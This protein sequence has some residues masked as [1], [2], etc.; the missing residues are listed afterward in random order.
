[1][2]LAVVQHQPYVSNRGTPAVPSITFGAGPTN[3]N[4]MIAVLYAFNRSSA[5]SPAVASGWTQSSLFSTTDGLGF[6]VY[7]LVAY[8]YAGASEPTAQSCTSTSYA[9]ACME[10]WEVSGVTGTFANDHVADTNGINAAPWTSGTMTIASVTTSANNELMLGLTA[11]YNGGLSASANTMS[12]SGQTNDDQPSN[13]NGPE[14]LSAFH[15]AFST[16]GTATPTYTC[17]FGGNSGGSYAL[18][19]LKA[20]ASS[21][22]T[23]T[24]SMALPGVSFSAGGARTE[25]STATLALPK[26]NFSAAA[27]RTATI[28]VTM[29][30]NGI[31]IA[32][33][34]TDV[35]AVSKLRQFQT[36]G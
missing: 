11:E 6:H 25:T 4:L 30:L 33:H 7:L 35:S 1:M 21:T 8:R 31:Q 32:A 27:L 9:E 18:V 26:A 17:T 16:S 15:E 3:G 24:A 19:Q 22:E 28:A 5:Q 10:I 12:A 34:A 13:A 29:S 14:T 23:S 20:P 36:F 2:A